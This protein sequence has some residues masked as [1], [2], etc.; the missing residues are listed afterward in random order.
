MV[1]EGYIFPWIDGPPPLSPVPIPFSPPLDAQQLLVLEEEIQS[2]LAK[3]ATTIVSKPGPGF[4]SRLF[5]VP[6]KTGD[7]RP[8]LDLSPL[9]QYVKRI[10]FKMETLSDLRLTIQ[11]GDWATSIDLKDAYFHVTIHPS[12]RRFLRFVWKDQVY[13]FVALPFGLSLAPLIF[14]KVVAA[15]ITLLR[16]EGIRLRA[17]LDD[18]LNLANSQ[19]RCSQ[20]TER[21]LARTQEFGFVV[22]PEKSNLTP[23]QTFQYLGVI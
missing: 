12:R 2:L 4:Y 11:P 8:V 13:Q 7:W 19:R 10:S 5:C 6:K 14:T 18:W 1:R 21:V 9:N 17:Y 16:T 22:K 3:G 15:F 20:S 23:S